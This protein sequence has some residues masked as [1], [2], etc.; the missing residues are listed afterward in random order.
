MAAKRT[1]LGQDPDILLA[2]LAN[3]LSWLVT[4]FAPSLLPLLLPTSPE[5]DTEGDGTRSR[6]DSR[7]RCISIGRP[8]GMEQLRLVTLKEGICTIGYNVRHVSSPPY[9]AADLRTTLP[10]DCV[11]IRNEAFSVNYADCTIRWGLYESAKKFV[12]WPIVP[13]FDVA[14]NVEFV[15]NDCGNNEPHKLKVGDRVFGCTLFGAYSDRICCPTKQLR[16]IPDCIESFAEAAA[17]PAVS[18]TALYAL[19]LAG[20]FPITAGG[21]SRYQFTNKSILIH[22]AAGGVGSFLVQMSKI[23]GLHVVGVVGST[24]KVDDA[25]SL[26]C[27]VV[28]D[29]STE[30]LWT[31]AEMASPEGYA[32]IMD[33]NGVSTL[34]E[35]YNHLAPSGRLVVFGFHSNLPMGSSMLNPLE[36]V[37]MAKKAASLPKFDAMDLTVANKSILGFNL[38]F[39]SE[40]TEVLS[41]MFDQVLE[42]I[43]EGKLSCPRICEMP[44]ERIA[45]AHAYI[46][47][48]QSSGKII[49][50]TSKTKYA[51][52]MQSMLTECNRGV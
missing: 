37:R 6:G 5:E 16:K 26:G 39:F 8:G 50:T 4:T 38:S 14:G 32:T 43:E 52:R 15:S 35:S 40:E 27:D 3:I 19:H 28:I 34:Q 47:S 2:A 31:M 18:L 1:I 45:E 29:K 10:A 46:Q 25:K 7:T 36:W 51:D 17:F 33:A 9:T 23:L 41:G 48:G 49:L 22:S 30:N 21:G 13:G 12:G 44:M 11:I 42:W 20:Y 24:S